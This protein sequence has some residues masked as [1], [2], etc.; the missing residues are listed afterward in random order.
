VYGPVNAAFSEQ[1]AAF[2]PAAD[3][4]TIEATRQLRAD[5]ADG[6]LDG[7]DGSAAVAGAASRSYDPSRFGID[8][9][10][11]IGTVAFRYGADETRGLLPEAV[12]FA[13]CGYDRYLY[14][15]QLGPDG[16][17]YSAKGRST[18]RATVLLG[19]GDNLA[20]ELGTGTIGTG[21][22]PASLVPV[23]G[24]VNPTH[25]AGGTRHTL[26]RQADGQ[27][28]SWGDS[29][30]CALG[31][32]SGSR[33]APGPVA[34]PADAGLAVSVAAAGETSCA[35]TDTGRV[36]A[37]GANFA[38]SLGDGTNLGTTV[39][40]CTIR[41]V[42]TAIGQPLADIVSISAG[43]AAAVA[44]R[45]DGAVFTWG[46][47]QTF[48]T[49]VA[50]LPSS[51]VKVATDQLNAAG[52]AQA[53]AALGEDGVAWI[54]GR[55]ERY[56]EASD[57]ACVGKTCVTE[58]PAPV[59][60][61]GLPLVRDLLPGGYARMAAGSS[62]LYAPDTPRL[63]TLVNATDCAGA[64]GRSPAP[65]RCRRPRSRRSPTTARRRWPATWSAAGP[66][67][68]SSRSPGGSSGSVRTS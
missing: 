59:R 23:R 50:G 63:R 31:A 38:G 36:L 30:G 46:S 66:R 1:V 19:I 40:T 3:R 60:L 39:A 25:L 4:P 8:L 42:L 20:G 55:V 45:S 5:L 47:G 29:S 11:A 48:A 56:R 62:S 57:T 49:R 54:W 35:L 67:A 27:L 37:W 17:A 24:I 51:I 44:V 13:H 12:A 68:R 32:T 10:S 52:G 7:R 28:L 53:F 65:G 6:R 18:P 43:G 9:N 33:S 16:R 21:G 26:A 22:L 34:L 64:C 14:D 2:N 61:E 58:L 15:A 41:P